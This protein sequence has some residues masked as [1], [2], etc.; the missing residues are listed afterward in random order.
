MALIKC[1]GSGSSGN[2]WVLDDGK[3]IL[4]IDCGVPVKDMKI[5]IDFQIIRVVGCIVSHSHR[6]HEQARP[7]RLPSPHHG[8]ALEIPERTA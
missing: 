8:D 4:V 6:D 3:E 1:I 7:P 5:G 2:C